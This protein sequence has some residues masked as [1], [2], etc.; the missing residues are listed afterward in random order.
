MNAGERNCGEVNQ[1]GSAKRNT[2]S[3]LRAWLIK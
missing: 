3:P 1:S 2:D